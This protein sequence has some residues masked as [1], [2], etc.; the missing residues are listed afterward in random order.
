MT[1]VNVGAVWGIARCTTSDADPLPQLRIELGAKRGDDLSRLLLSEPAQQK[2]LIGERETG[3][4]ILR[5]D[6][7]RSG[8]DQR[9][10]VPIVSGADHAG[11]GRF[12]LAGELQDPFDGG[13]PI[14]RDDDQPGFCEADGSQ[15]PAMRSITVDSRVTPSLGFLETREVRFDRDA[16]VS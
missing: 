9:R 5:E 12:L 1:I 15:D 10:D 14:E 16:A 4:E 11:N 13:M 2:R 8:I 3:C 7:R 6:D